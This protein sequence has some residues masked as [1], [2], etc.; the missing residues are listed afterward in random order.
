MADPPWMERGGGKSKRGA[1]RHYP[2]MHTEAICD[3]YVQ[4]HV[5]QDGCHLYLWV[6]NNF[7]PDGLRVMDAWGFVYITC[8]TWA[9]YKIGLGQYYRGQTEHILFGR[10]KKVLPYKTNASGKREQGSTLFHAP[11]TRHSAKP[12]EA[13]HI[14]DRVS[15]GPRLE[16]FA[17]ESQPGWDAWGN[18]LHNDVPMRRRSELGQIELNIK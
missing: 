7:L 17:R 3:L 12:P 6:T 2:L 8:I 4:E 11:R 1:D 15:Y 9:K 5:H 14:I 16:M 10:T 18:E 13:R